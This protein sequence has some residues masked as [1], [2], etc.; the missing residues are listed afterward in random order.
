MLALENPHCGISGVPFMNS[1]TGELPTALSMAA[2]V[3]LDKRRVWRVAKREE[4]SGLWRGRR[5][6]RKTCA[7]Q[8]LFARTIVE[9]HTFPIADL[10]AMMSI[11]LLLNAKLLV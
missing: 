3:S 11:L 2:R 1:T 8:L 7:C 5:V 9:S 10:A 4:R 6:D